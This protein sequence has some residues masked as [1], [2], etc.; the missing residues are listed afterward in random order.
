MKRFTP[1]YL[2]PRSPWKNRRKGR[3]NTPSPPIHSWARFG[4]RRSNTTIF[5]RTYFSDER[6]REN[7]SMSEVRGEKTRAHLA[8]YF[9]H[10]KIDRRRSNLATEETAY[11]CFSYKLNS[12]HVKYYRLLKATSC[13]HTYVRMCAICRYFSAP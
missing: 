6:V 2:E 4:A 9:G 5:R 1:E 13:A 8:L 3:R 7:F 11:L 12:V 10:R